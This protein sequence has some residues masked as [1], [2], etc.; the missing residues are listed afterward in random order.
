MC[1]VY[2]FVGLQPM[3]CETSTLSV[4]RRRMV[5]ALI[6]FAMIYCVMVVYCAVSLIKADSECGVSY[7]LIRILAF[8]V[9]NRRVVRLR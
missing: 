6:M 3:V 7:L 5:C 2:F 8:L 4:V 1:V 9:R